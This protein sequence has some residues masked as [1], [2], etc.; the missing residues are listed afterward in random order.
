MCTISKHKATFGYQSRVPQDAVH[1][2]TKQALNRIAAAW[3]MKPTQ[4]ISTDWYVTKD[5]RFKEGLS[6]TSPN[7]HLFPDRCYVKL[8]VPQTGRATDGTRS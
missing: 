3:P 4:N 6:G 7:R 5:T 8:R 2:T 1:Y